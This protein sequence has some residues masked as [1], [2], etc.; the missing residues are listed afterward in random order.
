MLILFVQPERKYQSITPRLLVNWYRYVRGAYWL[1]LHS[2]SRQAWLRRRRKYVFRSIFKYLPGDMTLISPKELEY[3]YPL[4]FITLTIFG[5]EYK[6][7]N[8]GFLSCC[9]LH[10]RPNFP[11]LSNCDIALGRETIC[12]AHV[13][14]FYFRCSRK[15]GRKRLLASSCLSVCPFACNNSTHTGRIFMKYIWVYFQ[16]LLRNFRFN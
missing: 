3:Y 4:W 16:N 9:F 6:L 8:Y 1:H 14:L 5:K 10:S 13:K 2:Q 7:P 11:A 15:I 12:H